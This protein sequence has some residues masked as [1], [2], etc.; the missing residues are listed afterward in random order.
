[1]Q[2]KDAC[3]QEMDAQLMEW[4]TQIN[5][6]ITKI[7]NAGMVLKLKYAREINEIRAKQREAARKSKELE[8]AGDAGGEKSKLTADKIWKELRNRMTPSF[9]RNW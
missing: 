7:E 5:L 6:L 3:K 4:N 2:P 9:S 1:M 8:D